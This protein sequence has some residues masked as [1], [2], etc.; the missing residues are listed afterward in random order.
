MLEL[1]E[2]DEEANQT[3]EFLTGKGLEFHT[4]Y[5]HDAGPSLRMYNYIF[6]RKNACRKI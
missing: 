1:E 3:I 5:K 4:K 2:G 6:H